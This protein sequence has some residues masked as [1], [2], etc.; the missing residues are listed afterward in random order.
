MCG[1]P[2]PS[3]IAPATAR[4]ARPLDVG[5][6]AGSEACTLECAL[7]TERHGDS[8]SYRFEGTVTG[9]QIAGTLDLG[10]YLKARWT[11]RRPGSARPS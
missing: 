5:V 11:G 9:Q 7:V 4:P 6:L 8:L 2:L 1:A 10:E 3:S